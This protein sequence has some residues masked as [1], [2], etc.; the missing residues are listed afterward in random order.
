MPDEKTTPTPGETG[1][2]T[3]TTQPAGETADDKGKGSHMVPK[4]RLDQEISKRRAAEEQLDAVAKDLEA[5]VPEQF[6]DL[7]PAGLSAGERIKWIRAANARGLF[8]ASEPLPTDQTKPRITKPTP[9]PDALSS[10]M[11]MASGY[12][13]KKG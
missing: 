3:N 7:V 5:E 1:A 11:K 4:A 2:D 9:N 10:V 6:R 13:A 8:T 12:G